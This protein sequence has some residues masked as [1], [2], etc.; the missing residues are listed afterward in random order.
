MVPQSERQRWHTKPIS[1]MASAAEGVRLAYENLQFSAFA[2]AHLS[3]RR[4]GHLM[5]DPLQTTKWQPLSTR[6]RAEVAIMK[7]ELVFRR[8]TRA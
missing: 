6:P 2:Y 7:R 4:R 8:I 5:F 3:P 1:P